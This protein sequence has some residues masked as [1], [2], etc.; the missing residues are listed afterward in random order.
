MSYEEKGVWSFLFVV[1]VGYGIY[2]WFD[3]DAWAQTPEFFDDLVA[4]AQAEGAAVAREDGANYRRTLTYSKWWIGNMMAAYGPIRG[5][6]VALR[7]AMNIG[8]LA[9]SDRAPH[10][11]A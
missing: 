9:L 5:L 10:W 1:I 2:L 11:D 7:P 8:I 4:G 3:A 6:R